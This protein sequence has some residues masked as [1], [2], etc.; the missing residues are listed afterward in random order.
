M[1]IRNGL[2]KY[3]AIHHREVEDERAAQGKRHLK[4]LIVATEETID[5][6]GY[7]SF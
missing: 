1:Q 7:G 2:T 5:K 6:K 3:F 4:I